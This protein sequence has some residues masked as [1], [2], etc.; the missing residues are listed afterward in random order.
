V[1]PLGDVRG[2]CTVGCSRQGARSLR[3]PPSLWRNSSHTVYQIATG[4]GRMGR[5]AEQLS[6]ALQHPM[7]HESPKQLLGDF[8]AGNTPGGCS[9]EGFLGGLP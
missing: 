7:V 5:G 8:L 4:V 6:D 3:V 1:E 2:F 9:I